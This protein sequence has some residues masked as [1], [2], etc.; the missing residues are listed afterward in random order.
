[1]ILEVVRIEFLRYLCF[2]PRLPSEVVG[3]I[4]RQ[5]DLSSLVGDIANIDMLS[6]HLPRDMLVYSPKNKYSRII[7][8]LSLFT[9]ILLV[10]DLKA[11]LLITY[12]NVS[13]TFIKPHITMTKKS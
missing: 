8:Y 11:L 2:C 5:L 13:M 3:E 12:L 6:E 1:M 4:A 9:N 10:M 7:H